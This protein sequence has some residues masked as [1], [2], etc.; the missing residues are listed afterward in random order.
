MTDY[1]KFLRPKDTE[2]LS[3]S[4]VGFPRRPDFIGAPRDDGK[5]NF[6]A[7]IN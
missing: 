5:E 1:R 7:V 2:R 4:T 6:P 3:A